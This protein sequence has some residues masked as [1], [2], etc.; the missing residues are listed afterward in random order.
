MAPRGD[1]DVGDPAAA[2]SA[3]QH[4]RARATEDRRLLLWA[5]V[6]RRGARWPRAARA[7][8]RDVADLLC[9]RHADAGRRRVVRERRVVGRDGAARAAALARDRSQLHVPDRG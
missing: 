1:S 4:W 8:L 3:R 6:R 9:P 7:A 2:R 5:D